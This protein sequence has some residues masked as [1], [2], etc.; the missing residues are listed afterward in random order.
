FEFDSVKNASGVAQKNLSTRW[1]AKYMIPLPPLKVQQQIVEILDE[2]DELRKKRNNSLQLLA[3]LEKSFFTSR[4]GNPLQE[5]PW[6]KM[7][8]GEITEVITGNTPSRKTLEYYGDY[9]E[10]IKSD[11][12]NTPDHML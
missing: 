2:A 3:D 12:I 1:L 7:R 6:K 10:W 9:I 11:N 5:L 4:F 8:I